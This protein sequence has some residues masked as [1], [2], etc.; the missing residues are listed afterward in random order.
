MEI[1]ISEKEITAGVVAYLNSRG[2]NLDAATVQIDYTVGRKPA[3][4]TAVLIEGDRV[5]EVPAQTAPASKPEVLT[6]QANTS[7]ACGT[8]GVA[9]P[10]PELPKDPEPANVDPAPAEA[11]AAAPA[12]E[13]TS[14][15]K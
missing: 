7:G 13:G 11:A 9:D 8:A 1:R 3:G 12:E 14:L 6:G 4:V 2:F 5:A 15:F 10:A